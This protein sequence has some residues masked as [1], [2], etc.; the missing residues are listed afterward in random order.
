MDT[1]HGL[2]WQGGIWSAVAQVLAR[3]AGKTRNAKVDGAGHMVSV[4][5][6]FNL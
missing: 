5:L 6:I 4:T 1:Q 3:V 2:G